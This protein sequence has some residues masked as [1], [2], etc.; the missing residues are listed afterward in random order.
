M[1][2]LKKSDVR[3]SE[4]VSELV[5]YGSVLVFGGVVV[6]I[7]FGFEGSL[8]SRIDHGLVVV[9]G[10]FVRC[11]DFDHGTVTVYFDADDD[12]AVLVAV[13]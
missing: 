12:I 3:F 6:G 11:V 13:V 10:A 7:E 2:R 1:E 5:G 4:L 8:S 9:F